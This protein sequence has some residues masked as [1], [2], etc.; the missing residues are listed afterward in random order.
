MSHVSLIIYL[1]RIKLFKVVYFHLNIHA[2]FKSLIFI[3]FGFLIL[4]SYHA[5][6]KRLVS[7][8]NLNPIIK[9]IYYLSC[10]CLAGLPFLRAFFSKDFII[11]KIMENSLE[12]SY[13]I[14]L[15]LFLG[16]RIYY[17]IKLIILSSVLNSYS[18]IEKSYLGM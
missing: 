8:V 17:R 4:S 3:C 12:I 2:I 14:L 15:I 16:V 10:L 13:I 11:E 7:I 1:L 6:D 9:I 18:M 5:Q